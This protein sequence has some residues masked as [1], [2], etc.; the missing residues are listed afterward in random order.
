MCCGDPIP[1][2]F[3]NVED[4]FPDLAGIGEM[5]WPVIY[6]GEKTL[7]MV[8]SPVGTLSVLKDQQC[9]VIISGFSTSLDTCSDYLRDIKNNEANGNYEAKHTFGSLRRNFDKIFDGLGLYKKFGLKVTKTEDIEGYNWQLIKNIK[10]NPS[11]YPIL[12]TQALCC[13][14]TEEKSDA[15]RIISKIQ[16]PDLPPV[17][18][19]WVDSCLADWVNMIHDRKGRN[20]I[21]LLLGYRTG[22]G[23]NQPFTGC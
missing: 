16:D 10:S 4:K 15:N 14:G 5:E 9:K 19:G 21:L 23:K 6:D 12:L 20:C 3:D 22:G 17:F 18:R 2:N 7:I 11:K 13:M 8:H 1:F